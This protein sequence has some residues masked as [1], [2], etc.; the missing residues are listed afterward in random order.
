M[1]YHRIFKKI[2]EESN[3]KLSLLLL[4]HVCVKSALF[5]LIRKEDSSSNSHNKLTQTF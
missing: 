2:I 3:M 5:P 4:T 1:F